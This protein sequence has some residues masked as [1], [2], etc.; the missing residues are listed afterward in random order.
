M[1]SS[2]AIKR[3]GTEK[4]M[5]SAWCK[6]FLSPKVVLRWS[7]THLCATYCSGGIPSALTSSP[8]P[9]TLLALTTQTPVLEGDNSEVPVSQLN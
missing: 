9:S 7:E 8:V 1:Q 5:L 6:M 4:S 2:T 3:C